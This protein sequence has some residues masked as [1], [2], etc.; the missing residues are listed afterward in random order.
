MGRAI[1]KRVS[2][3]DVPNYPEYIKLLMRSE[4]ETSELLSALSI[5]VTEFFRDKGAF[6]SFQANVLRPLIKGKVAGSGGIIRIWSAGC[7]TGQETYT[8][9]MCLSEEAK[10]YGVPTLPLMSVLG[11]DL[12]LHAIARAKKGIYTEEEVKGVPDSYLAEYF[13]KKDGKYEVSDAIHKRTRFM[14]ENLLDKPSS[15]FFDAVV[16]RNVMIYFSRP[17]HDVVMSH[18][19]E[20]LRVDGYL[21]LGRTE[22]LI[23]QMRDKFE[24]LDQENR[25]LRKVA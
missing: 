20:A 24:V 9:T 21:M 1:R 25:I 12:S 7:A 11:T 6:E 10:K 19:H 18:L 5:N 17:T 8:L 3:A 23:G 15:R 2:R 16:C 22:A 13:V 14:R 4:E